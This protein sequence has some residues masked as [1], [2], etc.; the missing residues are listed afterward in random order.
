M[1]GEGIVIAGADTGVQWD[2]P[3][4]KK[5]YRGFDG[6][7]VDHNY[8]WHDAIHRAVVE[9][10]ENADSIPLFPATTINTALTPWAR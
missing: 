2:H 4:L 5:H 1:P 7:N 10:R 3:A 9:Q 8:S 6:K